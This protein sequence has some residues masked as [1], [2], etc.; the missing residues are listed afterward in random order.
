HTDKLIDWSIRNHPDRK[1]IEKSKI[2]DDYEKTNIWKITPAHSK[3]HPAIFPDELAEKVIRYYSFEN[4]VVLDPFSG[5]GTTCRVA[6]ELKRRFCYIEQKEEYV[7]NFKE[8]LQKWYFS[9]VE[10]IN[11]MNTSHIVTS[12]LLFG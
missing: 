2:A 10:E 11:F 12:Q 7:D 5:S 9:D 4:D 3:K 6:H 8:D 1:A